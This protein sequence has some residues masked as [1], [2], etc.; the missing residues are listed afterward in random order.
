M[1]AA[2]AA[3]V[4][5]LWQQKPKAHYTN[6]SVV[7]L[8]NSNDPRIKM[9]GTA[10]YVELSDEP[11][12]F[13][14]SND[15]GGIAI[16]FTGCFG[17]PVFTAAIEI[18]PEMRCIGPTY[19]C[20]AERDELLEVLFGCDRAEHHLADRRLTPRVEI[21][22]DGKQAHLYG[23]C[24]ICGDVFRQPLRWLSPATSWSTA[25]E[26]GARREQKRQI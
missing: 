24:Y 5:R 21:D 15:S 8:F 10:K 2:K 3:Q 4:A 1:G 22:C 23:K 17:A 14:F 25:T 6:E 16:F 11:G 19:V 26:V 12:F 18:T 13:V 20:D 7:V 9:N